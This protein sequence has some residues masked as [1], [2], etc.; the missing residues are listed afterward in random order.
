M[1]IIPQGVPEELRVGDTWEFDYVDAEYPPSDG[2]TLKLALRG[3][4]DGDVYN[5]EA[6]ESGSGDYY[7]FRETAG[8]TAGK[9]SGLYKWIAYVEK[10][11][12]PTL[13]RATLESGFALLQPDAVHA[14][15]LRSHAE[16]MVAALEA[17]IEAGSGDSMKLQVSI[18]GRSVTYDREAARRDLGHYRAEVYR[19]RYPGRIG[20]SVETT[21]RA[22]E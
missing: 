20:P 6:D 21:F 16:R 15:D 17:A 7:E 12:G 13:E 4:T 1:P 19:E 3:P 8:E 11:S 9:A 5:L 10:G 22:P 2:W 14:T 18:N